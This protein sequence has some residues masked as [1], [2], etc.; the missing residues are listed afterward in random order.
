MVDYVLPPSIPVNQ[1]DWQLVDYSAAQISAT[2]GA[3]RT[4]SRGQRWQVHP[5]WHDLIGDNRA[6][7]TAVLSAL[8]GKSN[9]LWLRDGSYGQ[10]GSF[11]APELLTNG[12]F[13]A[14]A[15]G[16]T[17]NGAA[18]LLGFNRIATLTSTSAALGSFSQQIA[19]VSGNAYCLRACIVDGPLTPSINLGVSMNTSALAYTSFSTTARGLIQVAALVGGAGTAQPQYPLVFSNAAAA[20]EFAMVTYA[21]LRRCA[22]AV[23]PS[24]LTYLSWLPIDALPVS[25]AGLLRAGDRV[26]INGEMKVVTFD[27]NSDSSGAGYLMFEPGLRK[28]VPDNSPIIIGEPMMKSVLMTDFVRPTRPGLFSDADI[29]LVEA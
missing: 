17:V 13:A 25:T 14:G 6:A 29:T 18:T 22:L 15:A 11:P 24:A 19:L 2:S 21:S 9:R 1:D 23:N 8:R 3:V 28:L 4:I 27:L 10:R 16:W 7:L 5:Q 12:S 26:E 20:G